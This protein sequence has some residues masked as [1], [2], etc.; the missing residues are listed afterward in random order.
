[1][2]L[3]RIKTIPINQ[4]AILLVDVQNSEIDNYHKENYPW[5]YQQI[6]EICLPNMKQIIELGRSLNMEIVYTTIESL[7]SD[8][9][10]RSL[11]HKLSNI[12]IPKNSYF[13]K[14]VDEVKP[15]E[16]D[17]WLKKT[18][19][20]VFNSTNI[21][22]ILRNLEKNYLIIMGMLTDQCVDMA[23]RDGADKGY[24]V[25]CIKDACTTHTLE[26]HENALN[27]FKGYCTIL[28]TKEFIKKIQ[29]SNKNSIEKSNE[30][31]PM[32]LTTLVTTDLIGITRGRSVL[33]SKLDEYMTT[34]CGWVPADS[35]LTP[36]DIID[37]SN[38]W[39]SQGDLRLLPDKN[40][41]I[42]IPNGPNLK[43]QPFDLIHC[44]I[45]ETNGNNW[46]CC[47]RNLLKKEIKYYKDKFDIDINVSFEHEFT[48]INKNDSNS[49]PAFSFQSQR[50]QNQFSSWLMSSL[51]YA[52]I[53]PENFLSEYG[54]NQYEIT[55]KPSDPL[56]A[57]DRAVSIREI[58]RDLAQQMD[59]NVSFSPLTS[60]NSI[61][62]GV[63]LHISMKDSN[64]NYLFYD[65]QRPY[66]LS[67]LGEQWSS[68][69]LDHLRSL[70]AITAP[71]P[72]SYLRLK[73][74]NWSSAYTSIG[75]RNRKTPIRIC[76]TIDFSNKSIDQQYNLEYRP[77]DGTSSPH[78]SLLSILIAGRLGIEDKSQLK[79]ITEK[80]PHELSEDQRL[81]NNIY[82]LPDNLNEALKYLNDDQQLLKHFPKILIQTYLSMKYKELSLTNQ[83]D[84]DT[85]CKHYSKIY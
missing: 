76:P 52:N 33:T 82:P 31:K 21:D 62:N 37:E 34:G 70:C 14:V 73:P 6:T 69:I 46:D 80:D 53:Q 35:A 81:Q 74:N 10:D 32:S 75:Y 85:L 50:Q 4:T 23:I 15:N 19:S 47:P 12:F 78:L 26:R 8:G 20:G 45:V 60:A 57:A 54:K 24:Q 42:T 67:I 18:S 22:Y 2:S 63:H 25:I 77:M 29:E 11:D 49:Y 68:G 43:N 55:C 27:A 51:E 7:T 38:S 44:D 71:T 61:S 84:D 36:Q 83:F 30:I 48:L 66:N 1:M 58:I 17:I 9:R 13:G 79:F 56:T 39:G 3:E 64:G 5:Y 41:R 28:N 72:V 16:D 59:L 40:A 65:K